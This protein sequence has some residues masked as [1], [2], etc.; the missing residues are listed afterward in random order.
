MANID[1]ITQIVETFYK[2][3]KGI[4]LPEL[5]LLC[6]FSTNEEVNDKV[7]ELI[8]ANKIKFVENKLVPFE[9]IQN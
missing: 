1:Q 2:I 4:Q 7:G 8:S 3:K 5:Y 6:N 9:T